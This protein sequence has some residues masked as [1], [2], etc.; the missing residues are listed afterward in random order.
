MSLNRRLVLATASAALLTGAPALLP[1]RAQQ[2]TQQ[3]A[4]RQALLMPGKR[5]LRQRILTRPGAALRPQPAAPATAAPANP[6][7]PMF[8]FARTQGPD[9]KPWL[10]LGPAS[11]GATQGWLPE[12]QTIPWQHT[13]TAAFHSPAGRER[14]LFFR[15][16]DTLLAML[17]GGSPPQEARQ[18][19]QIAQRPQRPENF[20]VVAI[21]PAEHI[22]IKR[23]FY[24]LPILQ[25]ESVSFQDG[26]EYRMLEVAS[27]PIGGAAPAQSQTPFTVGIAFVVDTTLS[28]DPYIDKVRAALTEF[29]R[30]TAAEPGAPTRYALV[31][32]RNSLQ[33]QSRLEYLHRTFARFADSTDAD[34]FIRKIQDIRAT[35]VDSLSF[36]EDSFAAISEAIDSLDW[37]EIQGRVIILVTDAGSL[38]AND[39]FS[40]TGMRPEEL[41]EKARAAGVAL[42]AL[43]LKTP[44]GRNN[45]AYAERQYTTLTAAPLPTLGPQYFP[46]P[47]GDPDALDRTVRDML[48]KLRAVRSDQAAAQARTAPPAPED[49]AAMVGHALRLAWLGRQDRAAAPDLLRAWAPDGYKGTNPPECLEVR[50]LLT[51]NQLNDLAQALRIIIDEGRSGMLGDEAMFDRLQTVA[52]HLARDP[53]ALRQRGL[54][55]LG[56]VL[57]EYLD[58]LPYVS[59]VATMDR[60]T[61]RNM[62]AGAQ[63]EFLDKLESRLRLYQ[64]FNRTPELWKAFDDGRDPGEAVFPVPL[65]ALP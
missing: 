5:T 64:D 60:A 25:A 18:L 50:V 43:H 44:Q 46:V 36:N 55:S 37:G 14:T 30:A 39:R 11:R 21:E 13:M 22:D 65:S 16:R 41:G 6:L 32:F 17:G 31:G 7:T 33:R 49:R 58:D 20:P 10:E 51:R 12:E 28:M 52:A 61:W 56:G 34:G 24:L 3:A 38:A 42:M 40:T 26:R 53:E 29:V 45:H 27:I 4:Q 59:D 19:A 2:A 35:T 9:G 57:G 8:V 48:S 54:E 15:D 63:T 23:Q 47:N 1:A 62:G